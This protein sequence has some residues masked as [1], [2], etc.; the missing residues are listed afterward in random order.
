MKAIVL[1]LGTCTLLSC[2]SISA[3]EA[4]TPSLT[5]SPLGS[6]QLTMYRDFL[7][8]WNAGAKTPLHVA[9]TTE[10]FS[11]W[12]DDLKGCLK[13]FPKGRTATVHAL[14]DRA[15][16]GLNVLL[17]DPRS[18]EKRDP[19]DAVRS[20][21]PVPNAVNASF[22]AGIFTFSEMVLNSEHTR[23]A[24]TY[25]FVCGVRCGSGGTIIFQHKNGKWAQQK[26]A[27]GSW[28]S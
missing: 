10:P 18:S 14:P 3:Q 16:D 9:N 24:F 5:T 12:D 15:F 27:C 17:V 1:L 8:T 7:T 21:D 22:A 20:G 11:P 26:N 19:E 4:A 13:D 25:S 28:I 23:A 6:A 2:A